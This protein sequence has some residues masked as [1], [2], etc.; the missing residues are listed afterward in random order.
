MSEVFF[1]TSHDLLQ[2]LNDEVEIQPK[3]D[4]EKIIVVPHEG[5]KILAD[6][7]NHRNTTFINTISGSYDIDKMSITLSMLIKFYDM[8]EH[9]GYPDDTRFVVGCSYDNRI[10]MEAVEYMW[11]NTDR[12]VVVNYM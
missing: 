3:G 12:E 9:F 2:C 7:S 6:M 10:V 1:F 8:D 4:Y 5:C 11:R